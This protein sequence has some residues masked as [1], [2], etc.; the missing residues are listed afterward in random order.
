MQGSPGVSMVAMPR[1]LINSRPGSPQPTTPR[2]N[3][4][5]RGVPGQ[6]TTSPM[7][8]GGFLAPTLSARVPVNPGDTHQDIDDRAAADPFLSPQRQRRRRDA[9]GLSSHLSS[10]FVE[11]CE[12]VSLGCFCAVAHAL[13]SLGLGKHAYPFD[14]NRSPLAGVIHLLERGFAD[15]LTHTFVRDEGHKGIV[16]GGSS[17]GGSFWHHDI[18]KQK[19]KDDFKRRIQRFYGLKEVP[20]TQPRVFVRAVNST[21]ELSMIL[22]LFGIL[23][24]TLPDAKLKLLVLVDLQVSTGVVRVTD[25][26][27]DDVLFARIHES[28]FAHSAR[29]WT[30]EKHSN[31]YAE[32]I[33][34]CVLVWAGMHTAQVR[35]VACLEELQRVCDPF[36]GGSTRDSL[37][38]PCRVAR[39]PESSPVRRRS[40]SPASCPPR[41]PELPVSCLKRRSTVDSVAGDSAPGCP[42]EPDSPRSVRSATSVSSTRWPRNGDVEFDGAPAQLHSP[43]SFRNPSVERHETQGPTFPTSR[44]VQLFGNGLGTGSARISHA[45]SFK[46]TSFSG[47]PTVVRGQEAPGSADLGS[48]SVGQCVTYFCDLN[49]VQFQRERSLSRDGG[50]RALNPSRPTSPAQSPRSLTPRRALGSAHMRLPSKSYQG[51]V[52]SVQLPFRAPAPGSAHMRLSANPP[53][54]SRARP[55]LEEDSPSPRVVSRQRAMQEPQSRSLKAKYCGGPESP[56]ASP[57]SGGSQRLA[58]ARTPHGFNT[59]PQGRP[60]SLSLTTPHSPAPTQRRTTQVMPTT[61]RLCGGSPRQPRWPFQNAIG[62]PGA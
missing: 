45:G 3:S 35:D 62:V 20:A 57:R 7:M 59:H 44:F 6:S 48:A 52:G 53:P 2:T 5:R 42:S 18:S 27:Y 11:N 23:R 25:E 14:W 26:R 19:V 39:R 9:A 1:Q 60:S 34:A 17:W 47:H 30:I 28:L 55:C 13:R 10:H 36:D 16:F 4:A 43:R 32:A 50:K 41:R 58:Q 29:H 38:S 61:P 56:P 54:P 15:F 49:P 37:F 46:D 33:A 8:R 40:E 24:R 31:A 12:F 22:E 51:D 21:E